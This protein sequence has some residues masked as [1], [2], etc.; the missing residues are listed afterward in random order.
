MH[1]ELYETIKWYG[2]VCIAHGQLTFDTT[3]PTFSVP[4]SQNTLVDFYGMND[5]LKL[6][7]AL[8]TEIEVTPTMPIPAHV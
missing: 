4:Y 1:F 7:I 5:G 8:R 3:K 6:S 2:D